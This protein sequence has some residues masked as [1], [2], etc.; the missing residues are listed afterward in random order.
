MIYVSLLICKME[1]IVFPTLQN[2]C[3]KYVKL[4][5]PYLSQDA[6]SSRLQTLS[7]H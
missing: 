6:F 1:L 3:E 7:E 2:Y 5:L 4:F